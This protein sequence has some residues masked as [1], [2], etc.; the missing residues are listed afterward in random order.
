LVILLLLIMLLLFTSLSRRH[1][2]GPFPVVV[3]V[4]SC[5]VFGLLWL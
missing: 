4:L 3:S 5:V 2:R 1:E